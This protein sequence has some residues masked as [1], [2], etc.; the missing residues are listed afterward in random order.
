MCE[1]VCTMVTQRVDREMGSFSA[2]A[3]EGDD[4]ECRERPRVPFSISLPSPD[5]GDHLPRYGG[6]SNPRTKEE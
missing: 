1:I 4:S 3:N 5:V 2:V 6:L